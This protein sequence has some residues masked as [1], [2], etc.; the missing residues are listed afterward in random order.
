MRLKR[1]IH[2]ATRIIGL[3][4]TGIAITYVI[5]AFGDQWHQIA[6]QNLPVSLLRI[7]LPAA[8]IYSLIFI[9]MGIA[10]HHMIKQIDPTVTFPTGYW[11]F[12][13]SQLGKYLPGSMFHVAGRQILGKM[14]GLSQ[15]VLLAVSSCE[16][17]FQII[18]ST[19]IGGLGST[20]FLIKPEF[21]LAIVLSAFLLSFLLL[22]ILY[23]RRLS[24]WLAG[25]SP[26]FQQLQQF[27]QIGHVRY[28]ALPI[29]IYILH[30]VAIGAVISYIAFRLE[31]SFFSPLSIIHYTAIYSIA[32]LLGFIMPGAPGGIG[33]R[34]AILT[35]HMATFL[36]PS[37]ALLVAIGL[38][39]AAIIGDM[40]LF[41]T[42]FCVTPPHQH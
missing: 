23:A 14:C 3:V 6:R 25:R 15:S 9:F 20:L 34:E 33:V 19:T 24:E 41:L 40:A 37:D 1:S 7:T 8:L 42:S 11:I 10:W 2:I 22:F 27:R 13:R 36:G 12:S 32:W 26:R 18:V 17:I 39:L 29:V 38:R 30:F 35:T 31:A 28:F 5:S 4:I 16:I 21:R